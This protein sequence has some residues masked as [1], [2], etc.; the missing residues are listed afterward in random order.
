MKLLLRT[1]QVPHCTRRL[2]KPYPKAPTE[3]RSMQVPSWHL[4]M[5]ELSRLRRLFIVLLWAM[6]FLSFNEAPWAAMG[7]GNSEHA[8]GATTF[9]VLWFIQSQNEADA[10]I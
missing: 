4:P 5:N 10:Y 2:S 1:H 6:Q 7:R 8:V 9:Q 3:G